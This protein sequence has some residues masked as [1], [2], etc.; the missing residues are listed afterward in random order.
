MKI[1]D[2]PDYYEVEKKLKKKSFYYVHNKAFEY[3]LQ[4]VKAIEDS[5]EFEN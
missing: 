2:S 3:C 4:N 1:R 5:D